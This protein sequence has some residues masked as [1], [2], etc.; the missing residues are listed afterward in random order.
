M[1]VRGRVEDDVGPVALEHLAQ[2]LAVAHVGE[3]GHARGEAALVDELALDVEERALG[4]VDEH[5]PRRL[6]ARDLAAELGADRAAGAGDEH[7]LALDVG[8]DGVDVDLDRLAAEQ[9]LDLDRAD[10][11]RRG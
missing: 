11:L 2:P 9:V 10:L 1:L 8:G 4:L 5:D 6:R 7:G 3:H